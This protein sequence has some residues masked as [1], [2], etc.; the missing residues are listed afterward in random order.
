[1]GHLNIVLLLLQSG[2]SPDVRNI[3]S[4]NLTMNLLSPV[5]NS[6]KHM[7]E[8]KETFLNNQCCVTVWQ[9]FLQTMRGFILINVLSLLISV[10]R[11]RFTWQH[12]Q[13]R[14]KWFAVC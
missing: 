11:Q 8:S 6:Q 10:L 14:W 12:E 4:S 3:V 13:V 5:V 7:S 2:A 9:I 1:M